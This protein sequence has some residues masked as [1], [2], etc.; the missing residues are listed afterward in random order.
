MAIEAIRERETL[1]EISAKYCISLVLISLEH[2]SKLWRI[3][4]HQFR[5]RRSV[6]L[7]GLDGRG[8]AKDIIGIEK[9]LE[10]IKYE[11]TYKQPED[12][13]TDLF[14]GIKRFI[15]DY[16]YHRTYQ[17]IGMQ[18]TVELYFGY[19]KYRIN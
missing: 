1:N 19:S 12:N 7:Q 10:T 11:N 4:N 16:T 15:K 3:R 5:S 9:F 14:N 6:H 2:L 18:I 13:G 17:G 8:R